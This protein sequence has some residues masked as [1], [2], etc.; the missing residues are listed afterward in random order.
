ML[1]HTLLH[2]RTTHYEYTSVKH[3][4]SRS[5]GGRISLLGPP[6]HRTTV[7]TVRGRGTRLTPN[8]PSSYTVTSRVSSYSRGLSSLKSNAAFHFGS[9]LFFMDFVCLLYPSKGEK[10]RFMFNL[11]G[12]WCQSV[13][14]KLRS[15]LHR[16]LQRHLGR[17]VFK[18]PRR[19]FAIM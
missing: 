7:Q 17:V 3:T 14:R 10:M 12:H 11:K 2:V 16:Y 5:I 1:T 15:F 9:R 8:T 13:V 18:G 4:R 6:F 19:P